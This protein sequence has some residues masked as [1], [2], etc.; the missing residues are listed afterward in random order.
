MRISANQVSAVIRTYLKNAMDRLDNDS[1]SGDLEEQRDE[2]TVSEDA[3]RI[4]YERIGKRLVQK[5][6]DQ[7]AADSLTAPQESVPRIP[8]P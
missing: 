4:L 6:R 2:V 5:L 7:M 8:T 1:S 3:R